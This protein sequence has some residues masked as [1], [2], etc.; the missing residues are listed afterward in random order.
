MYKHSY[1][2]GPKNR[3]TGAIQIHDLQNATFFSLQNTNLY[4]QSA[5]GLTVGVQCPSGARF[6]S[7]PYRSDRLWGPPSLPSNGY[8]GLFPLGYRGKQ[9]GREDDHS[10]PSNAEPKNGGAILPIPYMSSWRCA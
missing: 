7:S 10:P 4:A 5:T 8:Q 2:T 9:P 3:C 1:C 6:V